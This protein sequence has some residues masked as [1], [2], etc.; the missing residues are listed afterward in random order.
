MD[1]F[2][3]QVTDFSTSSKENA[4]TLI[5]NKFEQNVKVVLIANSVE[6]LL[7]VALEQGQEKVVSMLIEAGADVNAQGGHYGNALQ[8]ASWDGQ[9][10]VVSMLIER[11]ADVNAQGGHFGNAL[12]AAS[13]GGREKVVS[14]LI[15]R[16][17][18]VNAQGGQYGNALQTAL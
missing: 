18:D 2:C 17:A 1:T 10:K 11:G 3:S 4:K 9:E 14:M 5:W 15:E 16:G 13:W 8:A 6:E 7:L 12:Q